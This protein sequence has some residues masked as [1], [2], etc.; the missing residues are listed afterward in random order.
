MNA[1]VTRSDLLS[2]DEYEAKRV[3]MRKSVLDIK[4]PRKIAIGAAVTLLFENRDTVLYQIQEMLRI[5]R[6]T[7][8]A[9][10]EDELAA[11]NP[12]IPDGDNWKATMLIEYPDAEE[13]KVQLKYLKDVE[14]NVYAEIG[15]TRVVALADEDM[16]R[17]NDEKT[18]SV[19]FLRFQLDNELVKALRNGASLAFGIDHPY[20]NF[21]IDISGTESASSLT[22]DL[23]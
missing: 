22:G 16:E 9:G 21:N 11:Y 15:G 13:R 5:E 14:H 12:L 20:Y 4:K 8:E 1:Q 19:H 23:S 3:D 17:S 18:S 10:I 2:L 6:T 7:E